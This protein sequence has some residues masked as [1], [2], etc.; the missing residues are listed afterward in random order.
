MNSTAKMSKLVSALAL[1]LLVQAAYAADTLKSHFITMDSAIAMG[2]KHSHSLAMAE[3]QVSESQASLNE[4]KDMVMPNVDAG[5]AYTRLSNIPTEYINFPG[6]PPIPSTA[7]FPVILNNYAATISANES[8]FNGFKWKNGVLSLDYAEKASE[9][10]M[11]SK[12]SDVSIN[13]ITAYLNLFKLQK[14]KVLIDESLNEIKAHVNQVSDFA[15]HGL[16]TQNDVLRTK[17]QQ[18]N[19]ELTEIDIENQI[20]T[21]SYN[22]NIMLGLPENTRIQIDTTTIMADKTLQPM[23][24]YM[25][26]IADNRYDIKA[27][28]MQEKAEEAGIKVTQSDVYPKLM[29]GADYNYLRPNPRIIPPLDQFQPSWDI[30]IK[31]TYSLT[32][33]YDNKH[34]MQESRAKLTV[35]QE[36]YSQLTEGAKME[37]NQNYMQYK[38]ALQKIDVSQK[39]LD[40]ANENYR[41][42][43]SRYDNRVALL[44]DLLDANNF[45]L[46]AQ[47]NLISARADAQIAYYSL[48]KAT[49]D[50]INNST[51]SKK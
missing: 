11:Q 47:I 34:K 6:F 1:V 37:I 43:K 9:Y 3:A 35:A 26:R 29:V 50:L 17:L 12:K 46:N 49:G 7:L 48:L 41:M 25:Q 16:A 39:S 30:G 36:T 18:S 10:N 33:L 31:L 40:Q 13:I 5:L 45:L 32:G 15:S 19:I 24:V 4:V 2:I 51:T 8:V 28:E 44:T 22:L 42:E 20:E 38:Q 27:V 21:V 14:A 23:P